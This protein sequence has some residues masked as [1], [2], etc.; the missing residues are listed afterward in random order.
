MDLAPL[1]R[2]GLLDDTELAPLA[3]LS[4]DRTDYGAIYNLKPRLLESVYARFKAQRPALPYGDFTA[5]CQKNA[6]WLD[7]YAYFRALKDHFNGLAWWEWPLEVRDFA[8]ANKSQLRARLADAIAACQFGQYLFFSQWA[9]IRAAARERGIEIIG[10]LPIFVAGDS[11]DAAAITPPS[12][13]AACGP[14]AADA[15]AQTKSPMPRPR[16][17]LRNTATRWSGRRW[18]RGSGAAEKSGPAAWNGSRGSWLDGA[19]AWRGLRKRALRANVRE[20]PGP[21]GAIATVAQSRPY[22]GPSSHSRIRQPVQPCRGRFLKPASASL[23]EAK[24]S[25]I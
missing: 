17:R 18:R 15:A 10:D 8:R 14:A 11:A 3:A 25:G 5:F 7:A 23:R 2:A 1:V 22:E 4:A 21:H 13:G 9:L 24:V 19:G 20:S 6:D 16:R 12:C